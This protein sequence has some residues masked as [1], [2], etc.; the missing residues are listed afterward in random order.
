MREPHPIGNSE[1]R[2]ARDLLAPNGQEVH[3]VERAA[4][5]MNIGDF[6]DVRL[7]WEATGSEPF[8][9]ALQNA[10]PGWFNN[11][12]W[13]YWRSASPAAATVS[14]IEPIFDI[15]PSPQR[16]RKDFFLRQHWIW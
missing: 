3:L 7:V 9:E 10:E 15:L 13:A 14:T 1:G 4:Q 11:R 5:I 2:H 16:V 6:D 8:H 12:S